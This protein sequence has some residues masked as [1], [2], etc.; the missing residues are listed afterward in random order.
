[1]LNE[2]R[3]GGFFF[4]FLLHKLKSMKKLSVFIFICLLA[5]LRVFSQGVNFEKLTLRE[6]LNKAKAE[7]KL[8]F[9][10][11]YTTWCGPCIYMINNVFPQKE[12]GDFF[13]K[14][15][16]NV[17]FDM[18][19]GEGI[20]IKNKFQV[21]GY[22]TFLILTPEGDEQYRIVGGGE[23]KDFIKKIERGISAPKSHAMLEQEYQSGKMQKKDMI[24]YLLVLNDG[25]K[26]E[27][28]K[29][30]EVFEKLMKTIT[31]QDKMSA[32]FWPVFSD[33][34]FYPYSIAGLKFITD[35]YKSYVKNIGAEK[36]DA[37]LFD[38]YDVILKLLTISKKTDKMALDSIKQ[39]F[40]TINF[41]KKQQIGTKIEMA[42]AVSDNDINRFLTLLESN[43][44]IF[45]LNDIMGYAFFL[46][47]QDRNDQA[48]MARV[49][50]LGDVFIDQMKEDQSA[51]TYIKG[52]FSPFRKYSNVGVYWEDLS[53]HEALVLGGLS[54]K[55]I[56]VDCYT[57][58]CG[59]CQNMTKNIFP[60]KE[61]GDFFNSNFINIKID[62]EKG[63]GPEIA[64]KYGI[65]AYPTFLILRSDGS[66]QHRIL[67][68]GDAKSIIERS[69]EGL[70]EDTS[71]GSMDKKYEEGNRD[72]DFLVSYMKKLLTNYEMEKAVEVTGTLVNAL[73]D[74]EKV[75]PDYWFIYQNNNLSGL[76]SDN[77][78]YLVKYEKEFKKTFGEKKVED[79]IMD[80]YSTKLKP[81]LAGRDNSTSIGDLDKMQREVTACK[82][83]SKKEIL[84][85]I[86]LS[87][88]FLGKDVTVLMAT[89]KKEFKNL[90]SSNGVEVARF[91]LA[92]LNKNIQKDQEEQK[93][94]FNDLVNTLAKNIKDPVLR[95]RVQ[96]MTM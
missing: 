79:R 5:G 1:M 83:T 22:P 19:K 65:R 94:Q 2:V 43:A 84:S 15:F 53:L 20:E 9:L 88:V 76:G 8:V 68:G 50:K 80:V 78:N 93:K 74:A 96:S 66:V 30:K 6:A 82:F 58:W 33:P 10:D 81:I 21:Q 36:V 3:N 62:M 73:T 52:A 25:N 39:Q 59:P 4:I 29:V 11:C 23:L 63:D 24:D 89:S 87:K 7:K 40:N 41:S 38:E 91:V 42:A 55:L 45:S 77:F 34:Q 61:V 47:R 71:T 60:Q 17:K 35:N 48:L 86:E 54:K 49:A 18:E 56:F 27:K 75:S 32:I 37:Y 28:G 72:K 31:T 26:K 64:K 12:A 92:Y 16:V 67:G 85:A 51:V 44:S 57:T 46:E 13:N 95:D 90:K 69:K 70:N 14:H